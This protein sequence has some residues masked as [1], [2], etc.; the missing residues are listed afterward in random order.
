MEILTESVA[1]RPRDHIPHERVRPDF[2]RA[3]GGVQ[4]RLSDGMLSLNISRPQPNRI[5][6]A[7]GANGQIQ[8]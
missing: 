5:Q 3:P 2:V 6:I 7:V 1:P 8:I 4:A